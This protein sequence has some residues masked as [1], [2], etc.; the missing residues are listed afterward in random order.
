MK[1]IVKDLLTLLDIEQ[2][3]V[4]LFR[5]L[6]PAEAWQPVYGG[7]V[8]AQA[9]EAASRTVEE[10]NRMAHSLH[11]YFMKP[12]DITIPIL[13]SVD[14][15]RDG[16]SFATRQVVA[17]QRG[18]TIFTMY[19]SFHTTEEGLHHQVAMPEVKPPEEC[20]SDLELRE[21]HA[22]DIPAAY[23]HNTQPRPIEMRFVEPIN[24]FNPEVMPPYQHVWIRTVDKVPDDPRLNQC[25]L[26]YVS[27]LTLLDTC[28]RPHGI[29]WTDERFQ[30]T[31]LDH[32]FWFHQPAK[33]DDWLLYQQDSPYSGGARG[34]NRGSFFTQDGKLIASAT[35]EGL[36]RL[37]QP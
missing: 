36:I 11:G 8:I 24:D 29:G 33:A 10:G 6:S 18:Q 31:S 7:Q 22:A 2:L 21:Q 34:F 23:Q 35:Q 20:I 37:R 25:L 19:V 30:V 26:V 32:A 28:Y 5:G 1:K 17:V 27:D 9:L 12:G 14:R 16:R 13:Y 15:L 4:N 3:E